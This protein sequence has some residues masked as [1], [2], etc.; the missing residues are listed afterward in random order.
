MKKEEKKHPHIHVKDSYVSDAG[1]LVKNKFFQGVMRKVFNRRVS[2]GRILSKKFSLS[3]AGVKLRWYFNFLNDWY[4]EGGGK[5]ACFFT[6]EGAEILIIFV[7][8]DPNVDGALALPKAR[9]EYLHEREREKTKKDSKFVVDWDS[10][11]E[12]GDGNEYRFQYEALLEERGKKQEFFEYTLCE[13]FNKV[14]LRT[15]VPLTADERTLS[16]V[17]MIAKSLRVRH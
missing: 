17:E 16:D 1:L 10:I 8:G 4:A 9:D 13:G 15:L 11:I 6:E 7:K 3:F 12:E 14:V 5:V 2:R